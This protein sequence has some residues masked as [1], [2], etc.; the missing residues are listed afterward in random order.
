MSQETY[1]RCTLVLDY[2]GDLNKVQQNK[3]KLGGVDV[4][5]NRASLLREC[6][7]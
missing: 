4:N 3:E 6:L 7:K 2:G 1:P 5:N